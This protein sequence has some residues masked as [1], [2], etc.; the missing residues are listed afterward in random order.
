MISHYYSI[1]QAYG[2]VEIKIKASRFIARIYPF[3]SKEALSAILSQLKKKYHDASHICYAY[4]LGRGEETDKRTCDAGEP[5]GTAGLPIYMELKG[6]DL[7]EVLLTVIRYF[8][9]TKLG[10]GGLTKAYG[11]AAKTLISQIAIEKFAITHTV[12]CSF[13]F[14]LTG[15]IMPVIQRHQLQIVNQVFTASGI[16]IQLL[17]P[18]DKFSIISREITEKS[19]GQVT[20]EMNE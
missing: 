6:A 16:Q 14:A 4:R 7:V 10:C 3:H 1:T 18:H 9:G 8:G 15:D 19:M 17:I 12:C 20:L 13:P 2:P 5:S 11:L